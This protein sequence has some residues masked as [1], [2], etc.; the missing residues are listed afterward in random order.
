MR[1]L[2]TAIVVSV[3]S[4]E[5]FSQTSSFE[6]YYIAHD[7]ST[8][9][10]ELCDILDDVYKMARRYND[11]SVVFYL[12]N[13]D[14]PMVVR[15]NLP[16]DNRKDFEQLL[17]E[18]RM[19]DAHEINATKDYETIVNIINEHD[20]IDDNGVRKYTSVEFSWYVNPTFWN[21]KYNEMLI[22]ALYFN[23]DLDRYQDY[24]RFQ[25][26]HDGE[27]GLVVDEKEPFGPKNLVGDMPFQL[28]P[29]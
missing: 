6:F 8:P 12:P 9:V 3:I 24:V 15:M 28:L 11:K 2:L 25:I 18:L 23:L 22:A 16:G 7:R 19:K 4:L 26:W 14:E 21:F 10:N 20:F 29:Y 13:Y 1:R 17:G 27:D 5:C